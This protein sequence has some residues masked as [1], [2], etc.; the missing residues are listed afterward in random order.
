[1]CHMTRNP[2]FSTMATIEHLTNAQLRV[3]LVDVHRK[4]ADLQSQL[5]VLRAE[6]M[7]ISDA[8]DSIVYPVLSL[9]REMTSEIFLRYM[10]SLGDPY[11][12]RPTPLVLA[13]V[14]KHWREVALNC[15]RLWPAMTAPY[16]PSDPQILLNVL[17]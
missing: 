3:S 15:P 1:M 14:C 2:F 7:T 9:P 12:P 5:A 6:E 10:E 16:S 11:S 13:S 17:R 8:L 4:I